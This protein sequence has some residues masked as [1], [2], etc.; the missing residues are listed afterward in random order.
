M[1]LISNKG[2]IFFP[3]VIALAAVIF[4]PQSFSAELKTYSANYSANFNGM[5]IEANHR[6]EKL[7]NGQY[8]E[9]LKAKN[10][11]GKIN[12]QALFSISDTL[13]LIPQEYKYERSLV[14]VKRS[15]QQVFDWQ[16]QELRYT[17]KDKM[18]IVPL[19]PGAMDII[20]HKLQLRRDLESGKENFSYPVI[21]RGKLK[22]YDYKIISKNV[23]E[24]AIGPLNTVLVQRIRK[25][26]KRTT[27][28]WLASDWGYLAV[29]LEQIENGES[30]EMKIIN[31]QVGS[32]PMVSLKIATEK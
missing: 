14:G 23:L 11:F 9:T 7:E 28:I 25:D 30:H 13:D 6:L 31:G 16:K 15:E 4:L 12:E 29:Q 8:Q 20:T 26:R 18:T 3:A 27:K 17:K 1:I 32:I 19:Q 24:T 10:I 22:Q 21:S 5:E 2:N